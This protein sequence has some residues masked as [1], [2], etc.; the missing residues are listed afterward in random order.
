MNAFGNIRERDNN[1]H[2]IDAVHVID[3]Q[4]YFIAA[5]AFHI[6]FPWHLYFF[7]AIE[8]ESMLV[9]LFSNRIHK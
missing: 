9:K 6:S 3:L 8:A 5:T 2:D 7:I 1:H 4:A